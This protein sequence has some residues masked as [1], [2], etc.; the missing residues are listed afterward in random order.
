MFLVIVV[1][2]LVVGS[3]SAATMAPVEFSI[4]DYVRLDSDYVGHWRRR[5]CGVICHELA[6]HLTSEIT[7][8][9][10]SLLTY[11]DGK[12]VHSVTA[13]GFHDC[14]IE[15]TPPTEAGTVRSCIRLQDDRVFRAR[16]VANTRA[17]FFSRFL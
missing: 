9:G 6:M 14:G 2:V 4:M 16:S 1:T 11:Q 13:A 3:A 7:H 12:P 5:V 10:S 17:I 8:A 15:R